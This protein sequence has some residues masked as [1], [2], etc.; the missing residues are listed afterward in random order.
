MRRR[1]VNLMKRLE[2]VL[3]HAQLHR[4]RMILD[5]HAT[6]YT[7]IPNVTGYGHHGC[8]EGGLLM[9]VTIVTPDHVDPIVDALLPVLYERCGIVTIG[10][11]GVLNATH[12]VPEL[13][14]RPKVLHH[15]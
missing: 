7:V 3:E 14:D 8:R 9:I 1:I 6:G 15:L 4:V 5:E 11:V 13:K 10:E 12:F 2:I